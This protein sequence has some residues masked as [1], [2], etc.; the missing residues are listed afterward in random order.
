MVVERYLELGLQLGRHIDGFVDA[1]FGPPDIKARV[2]A[3]PVVATSSR[4]R[5]PGCARRP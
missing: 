1:Y 2:D 4:A 5:C 3:A